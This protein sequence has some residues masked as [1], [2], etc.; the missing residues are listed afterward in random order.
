[1]SK[2]H[3]SKVGKYMSMACL[4]F[5]CA[6]VQ[7]C[8][9]EY[10]YDDREPDF[11]G[12][13][14]YEYLEEKGNFTLFL[15]VIDDLEYDEVLSKTGSKTLFV[16]D[17]DAFKKGIKEEWGFDSYEQ[18][19]PAHK[20][21]ILNNAMLDNAYLLE[22]MANTA[23]PNEDS[24]P[25]IGRCLRQET[26]A[27]VTDTIGLFFQDE[28]PQNNPDWEPFYEKGIRLAL[29]GTKSTMVHFL[30]EQLYQNSISA[31]DLNIIL[32]K[33]YAA[34]VKD[35]FIFD[36][37]VID[38]NVTC[39]NGYVHQLDGLL[40][41]P[42][43]MAEEIRTN[44]ETDIFSRMLDRFAVPVPARKTGT[45]DL[46]GDFN[47]LYHYGDDANA[48]QVY[49]KRYYTTN[50]NRG[51]SGDFLTYIDINEIEHTAKGSLYFDPGWNEYKPGVNSSTTKENDMGVIFAPNDDALTTYFSKGEGQALIERFG[52]NVNDPFGAG[53]KEAIDSIPLEH[54]QHLVRNMMKNSFNAA[55]PS[56]FTSIMD[57]ARDPMGV[58]KSHVEECIIANNGLVYVTNQVYSPARYVAVTAPVLF[59][60]T[61]KIANWAIES[62]EYDKYLL[63][64]GSHFSLVVPSDG[65]MYYYDPYYINQPDPIMYIF[66]FNEKATSKSA[67][68]YAEKWTYDP[69][70]LEPL[71]NKGN[72]TSTGTSS[73]IANLLKQMYEYYIVVGDF[74]N[75]NKYHMTKGYGTI[76][77]ETDANNQVVNIIGGAQAE[78]NTMIP[79]GH[80]YPQKNGNT[81]RLD[82]GMIQPPTQSVYATLKKTEEFAEFLKLA[83]GS[84]T[85]LE[86]IKPKG[87]PE[88]DAEDSIARYKIFDLLGGLDYNVRTF[89]TY[90]Y[91]VYVPTNEKIQEAY[92]AG[93]PNWDDMEE[94]ANK[95]EEL[96]TEKTDKEN[97]LNDLEDPEQIAAAEA[98]IAELEAV[99]NQ[100]IAALKKDASL[101]VNFVKYH[102]QDNSVYVDNLPHSITEGEEV[103]YVV[104]YE[105]ATL[106]E[107]T[108]RFSTVKVR[109]HN[110]TIG[111]CGDFGE[112]EDDAFESHFN[113]CH[114]VTNGVEGQHYNIMTRD[115]EFSS[116]GQIE[117][118]SFAVVH[119]IDGF[120]VNDRIYDAEKGTFIK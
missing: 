32:N 13:S 68:I 20:R 30:E 77:V 44:G 48:E 103:K 50:S 7:S 39:K 87:I 1:M 25:V 117:T 3:T 27:A 41:P 34:T 49:V 15:K 71:E 55:V 5:V 104:K 47:R 93:L 100:R 106:D 69:V 40:I 70:T 114:V 98:E 36:K 6:T 81:Y 105:T 79:V 52:R 97:I 8:R 21:I 75:G 51:A 89:N 10:Y 56:R 28:L 72:E 119:Q 83:E 22:L 18:L 23:A 96:N 99:I 16:A 46:T 88:A 94:E 31:E 62:Y 35:A 86:T 66:K 112:K 102:I 2:R 53:L 59:S 24:E 11:L 9:D 57:D 90:H 42:S 74:T 19:T 118:S 107:K 38:Q 60:D 108:K 29:D 65:C 61:L 116:N 95:I 115:I 14:I 37:M 91:T 92:Q 80:T 67:K 84:N 101:I 26:S 12:A 85:V 111:I 64:M 45:E 82:V 58:E 73:K 17:D 4:L 120:L 78:N 76:K 33:K 63:S 110:N 113:Q 109:T 43:N 54:I